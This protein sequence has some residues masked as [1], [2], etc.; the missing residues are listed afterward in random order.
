MEVMVAISILSLLMVMLTTT[1]VHGMQLSRGMGV[2]LDNIN[3]GQL[4]M[5]AVT[6]TLRTAI[7]P[8][9]LDDI[10]CTGDNCG[11][12]AL[13]TATPTSLTFYANLNNTGLGPSL[14]SYYIEARSDNALYGALIQTTQAPIPG[15]DG[16]G[17]YSFCD[18]TVAGCAVTQR[19]VS[20]GLNPTTATFHYYDFDGELIDSDNL[21]AV[22]LAQVS[23]IDITLVVQ[24]NT[25]QNSA[26]PNTIVERVQLPNA[27]IN[28]LVQPEGTP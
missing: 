3:Q 25:I 22:Q 14:M 2:R 18:A 21:A 7:W 24:T 26:P 12:T 5:N 16:D 15:L 9:Q 1:I 4:G 10:D 27:D 23:S 17:K 28:I 13:T 8:K 11:A 19:A 20:R 6:K